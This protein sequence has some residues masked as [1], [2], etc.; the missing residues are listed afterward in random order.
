MLFLF[1]FSTRKRELG[2]E[3]EMVT[4]VLLSAF[5]SQIEVLLTIWIRSYLRFCTLM[6]QLSTVFHFL[7]LLDAR[8]FLCACMFSRERKL[9]KLLQWWLDFHLYLSLRRSDMFPP[10][11][12]APSEP[13]EGFPTHP[14]SV[15][16]TPTSIPPSKYWSSRWFGCDALEVDRCEFGQSK[17]TDLFHGACKP[18]TWCVPASNKQ[19][20]LHLACLTLQARV[21]RLLGGGIVDVNK[22]QMISTS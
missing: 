13:E 2:V 14:L 6:V 3:G 18:S 16:F 22:K 7:W 11:T 4:S 10:W 5:F 12:H 8:Q 17:R 21:K 15:L 19:M 20:M 9:L 1:K